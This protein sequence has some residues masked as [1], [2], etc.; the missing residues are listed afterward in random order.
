MVIGEAFAALVWMGTQLRKF[1]VASTTVGWVDTGIVNRKGGVELATV[2]RTMAP[3]TAVFRVQ[4]SAARTK[5]LYIL[6][7]ECLGGFSLRRKNNRCN[8][9]KTRL[10]STRFF[11]GFD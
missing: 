6:L 9:L 5:L 7:L 4:E 1:V 10:P 3:C 2:C 11:L 8:L